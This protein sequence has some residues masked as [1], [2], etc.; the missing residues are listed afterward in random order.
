MTDCLSTM[1]SAQH[2]PQCIKAWQDVLPEL[3]V[4]VVPQVTSLWDVAEG[5]RGQAQPN[6]LIPQHLK[7]LQQQQQQQQH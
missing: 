4:D 2:A 6:V 7:R 1:Q 5:L 3:Q